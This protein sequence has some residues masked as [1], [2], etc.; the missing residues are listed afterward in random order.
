MDSQ[1]IGGRT[2]RNRRSL[3]TKK[4]DDKEN[5]KVPLAT[6]TKTPAKTPR[7]KKPTQSLSSISDTVKPPITFASLK[8]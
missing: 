6:R 7:R 8:V 1:V 4:D 2:L 5:E 3:A